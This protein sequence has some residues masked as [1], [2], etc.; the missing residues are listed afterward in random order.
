MHLWNPNQKAPGTPWEAEL[1]ALMQR[2]MVTVQ[3]AERFRLY[4]RVQ[5][6]VATEQPLIFLVSPNVVVARSV[7]VGNLRPAILDHQTL[8]NIEELF[9]TQGGKGQ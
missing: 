4:A 9:L 3:P 6:I 1:D 2:Q 5:E 8:W 7:A